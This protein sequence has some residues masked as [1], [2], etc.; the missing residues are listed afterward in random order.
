M[1][2]GT[3]ARAWWF[4]GMAAVA[5]AACLVAAALV[6][7]S[8]LNVDG[9]GAAAKAVDQGHAVFH[10]SGYRTA[11]TAQPGG[12]RFAGRS[13]VFGLA[14]PGQ[15]PD[16][17]LFAPARRVQPGGPESVLPADIQPYLSFKLAPGAEIRVTA[18]IANEGVTDYIRGITVTP[19][20]FDALYKESEQRFGPILDRGHMFEL[21]F[22]GEGRIVRMIHYFSP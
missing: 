17:V 13:D 14:V 1:K 22:D 3:N 2:H 19:E 4:R 15:T 10:R 11:P 8:L 5:C 18:P 6:S 7:R 12:T 21:W 9:D 20:R 16:E